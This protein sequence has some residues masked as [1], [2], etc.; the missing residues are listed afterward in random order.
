MRRKHWIPALLLVSLAAVT[1]TSALQGIPETAEEAALP[2]ELRFPIADPVEQ[3][4]QAA[5]RGWP[6]IEHLSRAYWVPWTE[7]SFR[8]AALFG[9]PVLLIMTNGWSGSSRQMIEEVLTDPTVLRTVNES[10]IGI[11]V[12]ADRRPDIKERYQTGTWPVLAWL[13]PNGRPMLSQAND[14]GVAQ[15]ITTGNV[16]IQELLFLLVEGQKYWVKWPDLLLQ[17]GADWARR[18]GLDTQTT[19]QGPV[20]AVASDAVEAWLLGNAD[21]AGGGFGAAPKFLVPGL[22]EF[23]W[24]RA[25]RLRPALKEHSRTTLEKT[26]ASPL[27]D[28]AD[29]GIHRIAISPGWGEVQTEKMLA[30]N[31]A[32]LR[33]LHFALR[34]GATP[35]LADAA[36]KTARFMMSRLARQGGGFYLALRATDPDDS[37]AVEDRSDAVDPQVLAGPNGLAGAALIRTGSWLDDDAMIAAGRGALDLVL[38]S[39]IQRGRG[40]RH[41]IDPNPNPRVFLTAQ[42]DVAFGM[43]DAYESTGDRRYL[44]AARALVD[45]SE[46]NLGNPEEGLFDHLAEPGALGLLANPRHPLTPNVRLGR[47]ALRLALHLDEPRYREL[48]EKLLGAQAGDLTPFAIHGT[49]AALGIEEWIRP[50]LTIRIDGDP[51]SPA[52]GDLRREALRSP[53]PWTVV[54]TGS[55]EGASS[56][57][58]ERTGQTSTVKNADQMREAILALFGGS[59]P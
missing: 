9:R 47:T 14:L 19:N 35:V 32:F 54:L 53:W 20:D 55:A 30:G 16:S 48:A 31:A 46:L 57:T 26:I 59:A 38:D 44:D 42:A 4:A 49:E 29:G 23:A 58:L 2:E 6:G 52:T 22:H 25:G 27:Y 37:S 34:D 28:N 43:V 50:P 40:T 11:V 8:R 10:Y 51:S 12:N 36:E 39:A 3:P 24:I 7:L 13:L 18:E 41:V 56:A 15:P 21:R 1:P 33:E 5:Y 45:F 17:V